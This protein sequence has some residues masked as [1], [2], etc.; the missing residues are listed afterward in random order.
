MPILLGAKHQL[1]CRL[2]A[3]RIPQEV[4]DQRRRK[5]RE[6][7]NRKQLS[8][9][10]ETLFLSEWT[11]L[12]TNIPTSLVTFSEAFVLYRVRWQIELLF[13]LWK[14]CA[15]IDEWRSQNPNRILC[16]LN[17]KLIA[18]LIMHWQFAV[19]IWAIPAR[20][21]FKA[22]QVMQSFAA[23]LACSIHDTT[24]H[25][26]LLEIIH[27]VLVSTCSINQRRT[28]PNTFQYLSGGLA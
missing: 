16:E 14:S 1:P 27:R 13:K 12:I 20:S 19:A 6:H 15:K 11:L 3:Q 26:D 5:L 25:T 17:A 9:S 10:Q 21:L 23:A 7:A 2:L 18:V 8:I 4:A 28:R 22:V 24:R